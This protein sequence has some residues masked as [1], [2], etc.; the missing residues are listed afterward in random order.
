MS[1]EENMDYSNKKELKLDNLHENKYVEFNSFIKEHYQIK[2]LIEGAFGL[3]HKIIDTKTDTS[4]ALKIYTR[5]S[6]AFLE[7]INN[8]IEILNIFKDDFCENIIKCIGNPWIHDTYWC[9]M[10]ELLDI[11][12]YHD[13]KRRKFKG[14]KY[15]NVK[16]INYCLI[17][18]LNHLYKYNIIHLI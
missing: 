4:Y 2:K 11:N 6:G 8:E 1:N 5:N 12:V 7:C 3:V 13:L 9:F 14:Y 16:T 18:A 10:Y 17:N 15:N